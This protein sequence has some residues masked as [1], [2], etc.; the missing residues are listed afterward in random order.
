MTESTHHPEI[1]EDAKRYQ[2]RHAI[3]IAERHAAPRQLPEPTASEPYHNPLE[4]P[5]PAL[6][7]AAHREAIDYM[8]TIHRGDASE[9]LARIFELLKR[10]GR[11]Q[12]IIEG[13]DTGT[14]YDCIEYAEHMDSELTDSMFYLFQLVITPLVGTLNRAELR[15]MHRLQESEFY[16][17]AQEAN[18]AADLAEKIAEGLR[19]SQADLDKQNK[20]ASTAI[21]LRLRYL[22][23]CLRSNNR[24]WQ[25]TQ[26]DIREY[27]N[28]PRYESQRLIIKFRRYF[29]KQAQQRLGL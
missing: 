2:Q 22:Y 7:D 14:V 20:Q 28:L 8:D 6:N 26:D 18:N 19:L 29:D 12:E 4:L 9:S 21:L 5:E 1:A 13:V 27:G 15:L 17:Q 23:T 25:P 10:A 16:T 24:R 3:Q 11:Y